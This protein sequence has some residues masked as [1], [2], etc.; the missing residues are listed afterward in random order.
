MIIG[1]ETGIAAAMA[2]ES[3]IAPRD[4]PVRD[5]Q[6]ALLDKGYY[7]GDA[8]RRRALGFADQEST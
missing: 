8:E 2:A 7:L 1:E 3:K 6:R 5:L 4:L